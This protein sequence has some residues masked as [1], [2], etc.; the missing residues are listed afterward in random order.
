[1]NRASKS[2][3]TGTLWVV[4]DFLLLG[5]DWCYAPPLCVS[6]IARI[7]S[8]TQN[9]IRH[10]GLLVNELLKMNNLILHIDNCRA[11]V[12]PHLSGGRQNINFMGYL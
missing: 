3:T 11:G 10:V 6:L 9:W 8:H 7:Q 12:T 2:I 1:M 4:H 5:L